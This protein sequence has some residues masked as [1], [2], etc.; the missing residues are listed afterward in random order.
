LT[1]A[2]QFL[3]T[4]AI[5]HAGAISLSAWSAGAWLAGSRRPT[6]D[7]VR[8]LTLGGAALLF[9][10]TTWAAVCSLL[11][12][13][14]GF[15]VL[16]LVS[17]A[18]F[19]EGLLLSVFVAT[20]E[21]RASSRRGLGAAL[22]P[23][24]LLGVYWDAYHREP[25]AL[26]VRTHELDLSGRVPRGRLRLLHL[27]DLQSDQ[28]GPYEERV[29]EQ[30]RRLKPD[31]VVWTGDYVQPRLKPSRAETEARFREIL[32]RRPMEATLGS[33][34]VRGD[35]DINWPLVVAGTEIVP[36][37]GSSIR[38]ELPGGR[39]LRL[40]GLHPGTSRGHDVLGLA[41]M[42]GAAKDDELRIIVGHNPAF[43]RHLPALARADLALAGHTHGGQVR[44][45]FFGA[46][47][48]KSPLPRRY[49]SGL[50]AFEGIPIHVSAGIGM[51]RGSAPQVRFLCPPEICLLDIRY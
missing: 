40:I 2:G 8:A 24:M 33:Y 26:A 5:F 51:E 45:P 32:R 31:L 44:I 3:V 15:T 16:R 13:P 34:A 9:A 18:L 12:P 25:T 49:A 27:S 6:R 50:H 1:R 14:S 46:P 20:E 39:G 10:I 37:S 19:A 11:G 47:Y 35:V 38:L 29:M 36:L 23:L 42:L 48:T 21:W 41:R 28:I 22:I 43:V 7:K 30:A 17:Q 4:C